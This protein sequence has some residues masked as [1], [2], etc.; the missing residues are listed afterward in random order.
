[1][2]DLKSYEVRNYRQA[3]RPGPDVQ[4]RAFGTCKDVCRY[5]KRESSGY[6]HRG[7]SSRLLQV[8]ET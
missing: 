5:E 7:N 6:D 2:I 3:R 4:G 1:M 8:Q